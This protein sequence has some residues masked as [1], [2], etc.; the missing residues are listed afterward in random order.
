MEVETF[1]NIF[2]YQIIY[3][4]NNLKELKTNFRGMALAFVRNK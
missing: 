4:D 1:N 3:K 2:K